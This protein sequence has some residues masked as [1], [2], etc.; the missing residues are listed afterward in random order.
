MKKMRWI[1]PFTILSLP[2]WASASASASAS[3]PTLVHIFGDSIL[4]DNTPIQVDLQKYAPAAQFENFAKIGAGMRDGWAESIPSIY[5]IHKTPVPDV[6]I[7]DGGGNDVNSVR[8]KCLAFS[9]T[10]KDTIDDV[11]TKVEN[12]LGQMRDDGAADRERRR[13]VH[14][15]HEVPHGDDGR[16][17]IW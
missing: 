16:E 12:L 5:N 7:L 1:S 11:V 15:T 17:K 13:H 4:A 3:A 8:Q 6:V 9:Q 14:D 10:C 2:F